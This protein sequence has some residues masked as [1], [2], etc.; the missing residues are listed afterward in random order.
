MTK[1]RG[2]NSRP[3]TMKRNFVW[4]VLFALIAVLSILAV[5][6]QSKS[7]SAA[8]F[9]DY[10]QNANDA[11]IALALLGMLGFVIFEGLAILTVCKALGYKK[12]IQSGWTYASVDIYFSAITPS[13]TGGQPACAWF[14]M[15]D[16]LPGSVSSAVLIINLVFYTFSILIIGAMAFLCA[17]GLFF[18]FSLLSKL[19]ILIGYVALVAL[20]CFFILLLFRE[21]ILCTFAEQ[22]VTLLAKLRIVRRPVERI[23]K[24][25]ASV[26]RYKAC[27]VL[28]LQNKKAM[29]TA[30]LLNFLQRASQI[31]VAVFAYLSVGGSLRQAFRVWLVQ[32]YTVVGSN[33]VPIPGAMGVSDYLLFDGL[34]NMMSDAGA[35]NLELLTRALSFYS[36][37]LICGITVLA[38]CMHMKQN[39][40]R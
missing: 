8:D 6:A 28:I 9:W 19:L 39:K 5:T 21:K 33:C 40:D 2:D 31:T 36:M 16:G 10:I 35:V 32:A 12:S 3:A 1:G 4:M 23:E 7:F 27:A 34:G 15:R 24:L 13:A 18:G 37:I 38:K 11:Y 14:M 17:P 26:G 25:Q 22:L 20:G 29:L 30:F